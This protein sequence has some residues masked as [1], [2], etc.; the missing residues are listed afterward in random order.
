MH[1]ELKQEELYKHHNSYNPYSNIELK[2]SFSFPFH[3]KYVFSFVA[4]ILLTIANF[5]IKG[6]SYKTINLNTNTELFFQTFDIC[7]EFFLFFVFVL[8]FL[9]NRA[10]SL[11]AKIG[12]FV[13]LS[14]LLCICVLKLFVPKFNL[15]FPS[16]IIP[17]L[18]PSVYF[19]ELFGFVG[20]GIVLLLLIFCIIYKNKWLW[21]GTFL[22]FLMSFINIFIAWFTLGIGYDSSYCLYKSAIH[23]C[24]VFK[25]GFVFYLLSSLKVHKKE[26]AEYKEPDGISNAFYMFYKRAFDYSGVSSRMEMWVGAF[27]FIVSIVALL[28]ILGLL[29]PVPFVSYIT[30]YKYDITINFNLY[31]SFVFIPLILFGLYLLVRWLSAGL[32]LVVRRLRKKNINPV[33]FLIAYSGLLILFIEHANQASYSAFNEFLMFRI[34]SYLVCLVFGCVHAYLIHVLFFSRTDLFET[35]GAKIYNTYGNSGMKIEEAFAR[36]WD[37]AGDVSTPSTK[38][39]YNVLPFYFLFNL[40]AGS[41][42]VL[43]FLL[44]IILVFKELFFNNPDGLPLLFYPFNYSIL[45][46]D[47]LCL[48]LVIL[49]LY[50]NICVLV[51]MLF[52]SCISITARRLC[53]CGYSRFLML[54]SFVSLVFAIISICLDERLILAKCVF[55]FIFVWTTTYIIYICSTKDVK[56][57]LDDSDCCDNLKVDK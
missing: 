8:P 47:I 57:A 53:G 26:N 28:L 11:I 45:E 25:L 32:S 54:L 44:P 37:N 13:F 46:S 16:L 31:Y 56:K 34:W 10:F 42:I 50:F 21:G 36:L 4:I 39:E 23:L 29:V 1:S 15:I 9:K 17:D 14:V 24:N 41:I 12:S 20:V 3:G 27:A 38:L 52:I 19:N 30:S 35:E 43:V 2:S 49:P 7:S 6:L 18:V 48:N 40:L 33:M 5:V 22:F 51:L 55:S